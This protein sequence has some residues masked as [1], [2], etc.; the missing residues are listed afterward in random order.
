VIEC[1]ECPL[2]HVHSFESGD[3]G[4]DAVVTG[5]AELLAQSD[6]ELCASEAILTGESRRR[7]AASTTRAATSASSWSAMGPARALSII[8]HSPSSAEASAHCGSEKLARASSVRSRSNEL[9]V[10]ERGDVRSSSAATSPI[11]HRRPPGTSTSCAR[12]RTGASDVPPAREARASANSPRPWSATTT[13]PRCADLTAFAATSTRSSNAGRGL[14]ACR[15][16]VPSSSRRRIPAARQA[17]CSSFNP[18]R[19]ESG[20]NWRAH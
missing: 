15:R 1:V 19:A 14:A 12:R 9:T 3:A 2:Q 7:R 20:V 18:T 16:T 4:G 5:A 13:S 6:L 8:I 17:T 11:M 10:N